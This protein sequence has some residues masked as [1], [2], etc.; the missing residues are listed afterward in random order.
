VF[1]SV[2]TINVIDVVA[3]VCYSFGVFTFYRYRIH[4]L[5]EM[6]S[7]ELGVNRVLEVCKDGSSYN[8]LIK[9]K[10]SSAEGV[11]TG[12][13]WATFMSYVD[14]INKEVEKLKE[15]GEFKYVQHIGGGWHVSVTSGFRC[16]DFRR[17]YVN[18]NDQTKPTRHGIALR[19]H[20]WVKF[21]D[22]IKRL[23]ADIPELFT[24]KP[25]FHEEVSDWI[26]CL[27][28]FPFNG[29]KPVPSYSCASARY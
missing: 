1:S 3:V 13:R 22:V 9:D 24:I 8:V 2:A 14:D 28:C 23:P 16:V 26:N 12:L 19:L 5:S 10:V 7:Y 21:L 4:L 20:E 11:L 15:G 29:A 17:F 27:E 18:A 25:C 6:N